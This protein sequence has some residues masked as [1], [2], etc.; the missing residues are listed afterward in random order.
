MENLTSGPPQ[1]TPEPIWAETPKLSAVG[2]G[3]KKK[4][5]ISLQ[6][7]S[8]FWQWQMCKALPLPCLPC[9]HCLTCYLPS[10]CCFLHSL[11]SINVQ[12]PVIQPPTTSSLLCISSGFCPLTSERNT[13]AAMAA[14]LCRYS[15]N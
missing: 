10:L 3:K 2:G 13:I 12:R 15:Q 8:L 9:L 14:T 1:T 5:T 11:L 7:P 4:K 6:T